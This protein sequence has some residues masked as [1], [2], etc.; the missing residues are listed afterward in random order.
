MTTEAQLFKEGKYDELW[1]RCCGFIDLSLDDFMNIQR[2]LLLEQIEL[3]KRCE[4]G[5]VVM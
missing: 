3:L 4:L 5:R 2:R 1:E